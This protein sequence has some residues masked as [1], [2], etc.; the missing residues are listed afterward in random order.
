MSENWGLSDCLF[1]EN[2]AGELSKYTIA[3]LA[4]PADN[5]GEYE[6]V[7]LTYSWVW[8]GFLANCHVLT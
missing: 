6:L 1:T 4:L 2:V 3:G 7:F 5:S 8:E